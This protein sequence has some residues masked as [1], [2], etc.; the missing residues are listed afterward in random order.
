MDR[1][2]RASDQ[3]H[4]EAAGEGG[5]V[6]AGPQEMRESAG[7]PPALASSHRLD[8]GGNFATGLHFDGHEV[9][10]APGDEI[11]LARRH[12]KVPGEDAVPFQSQ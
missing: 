2:R 3:H 7:D 5:K 6:G 12:P 9:G 11:D 10:A 1:D 4:I 8:R